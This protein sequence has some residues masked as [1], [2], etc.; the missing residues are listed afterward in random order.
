MDLRSEEFGYSLCFVFIIVAVFFF[1]FLWFCFGGVVLCVGC[2]KYPNC[3]LLP[4]FLPRFPQG[5]AKLWIMIAYD[6]SCGLRFFFYFHFL[7]F[8][9]LS[10]R[11]LFGMMCRGYCKL[12]FLLL[13]FSF[14]PCF[15]HVAPSLCR[16]DGVLCTT[17][18]ACSKTKKTNASQRVDLLEFHTWEWCGL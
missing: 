8:V 14:L 18:F 7:F 6:F 11:M 9:L 3:F 15:M 17:V 16:R 13:L 12:F 4:F 10:L 5:R 2:S 1:L